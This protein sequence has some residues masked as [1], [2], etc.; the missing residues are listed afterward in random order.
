MQHVLDS[1]I[2]KIEVQQRENENTP[3]WCVGEQ[4]KDM[5]RSDQAVAELL[6]K[7]LDVE[8]MSI[9]EAEKK[10]KEY[11][12]KNRKGRCGFVPPNI[13]D[14]IL[15]KFYGLPA[16]DEAIEPTPEQASN[17]IIDLTAFL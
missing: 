2:A 10:I 13:A 5:S 6:D 11:A 16:R 7:D 1:V 3:A 12:D 9:V 14:E 4:L 17:K 15:R 8:S